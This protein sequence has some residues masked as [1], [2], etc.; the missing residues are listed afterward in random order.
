[1]KVIT[2]EYNDTLCMVC[3]LQ[4]HQASNHKKV[5]NSTAVV[6]RTKG[7]NKEKMPRNVNIH[8]SR[9]SKVQSC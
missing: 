8:L 1:M 6:N 5:T 7:C 9:R 4:T 3:I 2:K